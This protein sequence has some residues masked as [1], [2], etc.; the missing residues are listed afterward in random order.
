MVIM[1]EDRSKTKLWLIPSKLNRVPIETRSIR[2]DTQARWGYTSNFRSIGVYMLKLWMDQYSWKIISYT[3]WIRMC[4]T[5]LATQAGYGSIVMDQWIQ[6]DGCGSLLSY[7]IIHIDQTTSG[8]IRVLIAQFASGFKS[9]RIRIDWG[10]HWMDSKNSGIGWIRRHTSYRLIWKK[11]S[12]NG[13]Q[14]MDPKARLGWMV[15]WWIRTNGYEPMDTKSSAYTCKLELV[16][17]ISHNLHVETSW[18]LKSKDFALSS[19]TMIDLN[20][21]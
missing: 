7:R 18:N 14:N 15:I 21:F 3:I 9:I 1:I 20:W 17:I 12:R 11:Q 4:T 19:F 2:N 10:R 6:V 16:S 8:W 13:A 5:Q